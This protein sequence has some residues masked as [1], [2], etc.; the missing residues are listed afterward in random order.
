L[1]DNRLYPP[2]AALRAF[3]AVG[4][5]GGIRR[6]ARELSVDH[7]V[8]SRHI[9]S[10]EVWLGSPLL[11]RVGNERA[12]T[13]AGETFHR[14]IAQSLTMIAAATGRILN[15]EG[16]RNL[17]LCCVPGLATLWL[18]DL[19]GLFIEANP[20]LHVDFRPSDQS[21]DFRDQ[22]IDCD[23]RYWRNWETDKVPSGVIRFDFAEPEVYP[24]AS[25]ELLVNL[26]PIRSAEDLLQL[27]LL[28]EDNDSEWRH[29]LG[30]QGVQAP[31]KLPGPNLW[32]AHLTLNAAR[33]D[34][35]IA[36]ANHLLIGDELRSGRLVRINALEDAFAP[37][38][39]GSYA[40][41][42]REDRWNAPAVLLFR[43]WL[44]KM[45][46]QEE[47]ENNAAMA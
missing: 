10:L 2:L 25:P 20:Q 28:H 14:E 21:P 8:V 12:L 23:I 46:S 31:S 39:L 29:W 41:L 22:S 15:G 47:G 24:V 13:L 43:R 5:L 45:T 32:H 6:A 16:A 33:H 17:Y 34:R 35:G 1:A 18:S 11:T 38:Q 4:R 27:P 19:L 44:R 37:V 7:A 9:S 26:P 36:L 3:E 30:A 42:A 40:L